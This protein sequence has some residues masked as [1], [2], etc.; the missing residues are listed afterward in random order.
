MLIERPL[1]TYGTTHF[2][3]SLQIAVVALLDFLINT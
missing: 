2:Q 1:Y 3:V